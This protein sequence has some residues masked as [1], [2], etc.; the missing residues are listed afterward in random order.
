MKISTNVG[1]YK[2][3]IE[4]FQQLVQTLFKQ[5]F[6][7]RALKDFWR[8]IY[9]YKL[10]WTWLSISHTST[11]TLNWNCCGR[12]KQSQWNPPKTPRPHLLTF[13]AWPLL[14]IT[15]SI[16]ETAHKHRNSYISCQLSMQIALIQWTMKIIVRKAK[17]LWVI[18]G[19]IQSAIFTLVPFFK[20][21]GNSATWVESLRARTTT[22]FIG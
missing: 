6:F 14:P 16:S 15:K 10:R 12:K 4:N 11:K 2:H 18:Q 3:Q 1:N 5:K 21:F 17:S 8:F 22:I 7:W 13:W 19:L 9:V 20:G